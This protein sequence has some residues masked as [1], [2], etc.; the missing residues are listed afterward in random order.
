M[1][2]YL[3][4]KDADLVLF[5]ANFSAVLGV[6]AVAL[7]VTPAQATQYAGLADTFDTEL[8]GAVAARAT[9]R[10]ATDIKDQAKAELV[11][12]TR[13]LAQMFY[14]NPA[15]ADSLRSQLGLPVRDDDRTPAPPPTATPVPEVEKVGGSQVVLRVV[16]GET[17]KA[18]K[19]EGARGIQVFE[20]VVAHN[21]PAPSGIDQMTLVEVASSGRITRDYD[22]A[23]LCKTAYYAFRY[24]NVKGEAGPVSVIIPAS[25]AA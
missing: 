22:T 6:N 3:P 4:S 7:G 16:N 1:A 24:T 11:A 8:G 25:I 21:E 5:C 15:V 19:P 10:A 23:D 20:K 9:A 12:R 18:S 2:D 13:E 17:G 14:A